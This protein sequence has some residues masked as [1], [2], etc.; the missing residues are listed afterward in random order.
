AA[1]LDQAGFARLARVRLALEPKDAQV[2]PDQGMSAE[3]GDPTSFSATPG[4]HRIAVSAAGYDSASVDVMLA[5]S[6]EKRVSVTLER[7]SSLFSSPWFWVVTGVALALVVGG[8]VAWMNRPEV[9][10]VPPSG[11]DCRQ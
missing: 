4:L 10:C 3:R 5:T 7:D 2:V 1:L 8:S 11:A 6:E 9:V